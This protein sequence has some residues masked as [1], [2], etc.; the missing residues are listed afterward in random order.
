MSRDILIHEYF[1]VDSDILW[2]VISTHLDPLEEAAKRLM[3]GLDVD[4]E[5]E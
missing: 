3:S 2:D 1:G 5:T 4:D